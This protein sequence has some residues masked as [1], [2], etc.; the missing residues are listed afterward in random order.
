MRT[1]RAP[2]LAALLLALS[3]VACGGDQTPNAKTPAGGPPSAAGVA[4]SPG[5]A[6]EGQLEGNII[7]VETTGLH[8]I[9]G[10]TLQG[11]GK[12]YEIVIDPE[13]DYG[14]DLHHLMEHQDD[15]LPVR[16]SVEERN[17]KLYALEIEDA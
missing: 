2:T 7:K 3:L 17:G 10:F 16:V 14:F 13:R 4:N 11:G 15:K 5:A 1:K 8:E 9:S 6:D 12:R